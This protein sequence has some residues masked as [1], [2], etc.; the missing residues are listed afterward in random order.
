MNNGN[1]DSQSKS[2]LCM[3]TCHF[4]PLPQEG[5]HPEVTSSVGKKHSLTWTDVLQC[6]CILRN[7]CKPKK[8]IIYAESSI[9]QHLK[10]YRLE[11]SHTRVCV[12][13]WCLQSVILCQCGCS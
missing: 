2:S 12:C 3:K 9:V 10:I 4:P 7:R 6:L 5:V 13:V 1:T 11:D 8:C